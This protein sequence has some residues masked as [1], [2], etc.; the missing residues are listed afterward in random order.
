MR[1]TAKATANGKKIKTKLSDRSQALL[2]RIRHR[3]EEIRARAGVLSDSC[4]LIR[5]ERDRRF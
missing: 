2:E 3:R 1:R 4:E 5:K